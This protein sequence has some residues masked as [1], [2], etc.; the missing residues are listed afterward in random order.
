MHLLKSPHVEKCELERDL[1][2]VRPDVSA[3]IRGIPVAIEVQLSNLSI[4]RLA[5]RTSEYSRK[6]IYVLWLPLYTPALR[7][8]LYGPRP[9]ELWLHTIYQ[10][11]VYYWVEGLKIQPVH[12]REY[13]AQI[14]GRT[15]DYVRLSRRRVPLEGEPATLTEDFTRLSSR[16]TMSGK[17]CYPEMKLLV[18]RQPCW[19]WHDGINW[20]RRKF[21]HPA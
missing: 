4:E 10:G 13:Y 5:Y 2:T 18:D 6:G 9:W 1:G 7:K 12:F 8:E 11:R 17:N 20:L 14:N 19:Y 3:Y 21:S 16:S 15:R